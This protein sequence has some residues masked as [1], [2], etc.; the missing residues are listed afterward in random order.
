MMNSTHGIVVGPASTEA[1]VCDVKPGQLQ[2]QF[3]QSTA[4]AFCAKSA[5]V[6]MLAGV[7]AGFMLAFSLAL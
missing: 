3:E 7:F 1:G 4:K 6:W 5:L 2:S